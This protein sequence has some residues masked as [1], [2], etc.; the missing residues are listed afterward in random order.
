[1]LVYTNMPFLIYIFI[2][3][4]HHFNIYFR[5]KKQLKQHLNHLITNYHNITFKEKYPIL[6]SMFLHI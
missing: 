4:K 2:A 6:L 1:M 5:I 3:L